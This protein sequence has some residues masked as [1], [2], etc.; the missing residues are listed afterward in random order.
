MIERL[1]LRGAQDFAMIGTYSHNFGN[2]AAFADMLRAQGLQVEF[3]RYFFG[4]AIGV[5]GRKV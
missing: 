1:F 2:A 5:S 4:C 3:H